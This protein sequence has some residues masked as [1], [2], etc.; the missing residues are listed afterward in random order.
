MKPAIARLLQTLFQAVGLKTF[1]AQF[2]FA[3]VLVFLV[4]GLGVGSLLVRLGDDATVIDLAGRQRMLSQRVA[5]EAMLVAQGVESRET[6]NE[7]IRLFETSHKE[8]LNGNAEAGVEAVADPGLR[9]HLARVYGIWGTYKAEIN[10]YLDAPSPER[11][12]VIDEQSSIV[13]SEMNKGVAT[14]AAVANATVRGSQIFSLVAAGVALLIISIGRIYGEGLLMQGLEALRQRLVAV[15][16][17]DFSRPIEV[18]HRDNEL[19]DALTA[20]NDMLE[21]VSTVLGRVDATTSSVRGRAE[22]VN[23]ILA[24]ASSRAQQQ[25]SEIESAAT[26]MNEMSISV[27]EV[28]R[29]AAE[30]AEKVRLADSDA[31]AGRIRVADVIEDINSMAGQLEGTVE[32]M[33]H[34]EID[35]QEVGKVLAVING[36]AEQTNLLALNAA[37]EAARAGEMGRG[38]AVV[39]DEVR[40]LAQRTQASTKEIRDIIGRLQSRASEAL[41]EIESGRDHAQSSVAKSQDADAALDKIVVAVSAIRNMNAQIATAAE[42]QSRVAEE[43]NQGIANISLVADQRTIEAEDVVNTTAEIRAAMAELAE[44]VARFKLS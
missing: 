44:Q 6:V 17:G 4:T 10:R 41:V 8:L 5:K 36:I 28:A 29:N 30:A 1:R 31:E 32:V 43:L 33:K 22:Q 18:T 3:F 11:L 34:L 21:Q 26:G 24:D 39:A 12:R 27:L 16:Q 20:Y 35:S 37:I 38:F 15:G 2:L 42:E 25:R 13:L 19:A 7:T 40:T 9:Q 14:M 23:G